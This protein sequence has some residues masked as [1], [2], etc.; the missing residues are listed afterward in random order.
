MLRT[1]CTL[2]VATA[3]ASLAS[4]CTLCRQ[5][6]GRVAMAI[7]AAAHVRTART[8]ADRTTEGHSFDNSGHHHN[9]G[10]NS[11]CH[12][13]HSYCHNNSSFHDYCHRDCELL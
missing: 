3:L 10:P 6:P 9:S 1:S 2:L 12:N 7:L 4:M 8:T 5:W 11:Y 13:D